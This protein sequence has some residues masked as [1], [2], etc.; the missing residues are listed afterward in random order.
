MRKFIFIALF[1]VAVS[2]GLL[3][4][5]LHGFASDELSDSKIV[6]AL[7]EALFLGSKTAALNL[8]DS[9]CTTISG[10]TTGYLGNG[11]VEILL[12]DTV[13]KVLEFATAINNPQVQTIL[14]VVGIS[15]NALSSFDNYGNSIKKALNRGAERAAPESKEAFKDAIFGMSFSDARGI[16]FGDDSTAATTYLQNKTFSGLQSAF[17]PLIKESLDLLHPNDYWKPLVSSYKSFARTY[18]NLTNGIGGSTLPHLPYTPDELPDDLSAYLSEYATGKA[19]DGLFI[20]V[21]VQE[22]KLRRDPWGAISA[23]GDLVSSTV[24]DLLGSVFSKAKEG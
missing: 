5:G 2:L 11:L 22:A 16:L 24:G 21:G 14:S 4:C 1:S 23:V 10:C 8:G 13:R 7:Q 18:S 20:M 17:A 15:S 6:E 9:S 19:L 12:P 3:S